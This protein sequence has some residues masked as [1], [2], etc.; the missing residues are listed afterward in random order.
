MDYRGLNLVTIKFPFPV[1]I[2]AELVNELRHAKVFFKLDLRLGFYHIR[3]HVQDIPK[4]VF[5]THDGHFNF[6]VMP[7]G[8]CNAPST[9]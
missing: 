1:P 7:F 2:I 9:F 6:L 4:T 8:L 3:M 5:R